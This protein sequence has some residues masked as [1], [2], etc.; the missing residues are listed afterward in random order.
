MHDALNVL[1]FLSVT[2]VTRPLP[3][4]SETP[5]S[6]AAFQGNVAERTGS[7]PH[8]LHRHASRP[9]ALTPTSGGAGVSPKTAVGGSAVSQE[10]HGDR[11]GPCTSAAPFSEWLWGVEVCGPWFSEWL[12]GVEV[13]GPWASDS[14]WFSL[15]DEGIAW[16]WGGRSFVRATATG[17]AR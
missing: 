11:P 17:G 1:R 14:D 3:L 16:W 2:G 7:V 12:W 13:C 4:T 8:A 10:W 5:R 15:W 9:N 6:S